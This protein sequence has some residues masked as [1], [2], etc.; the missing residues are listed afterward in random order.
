MFKTYKASAGSGKTTRLVAEYISVCLKNPERFRNILAITFTNNATAEMKER[1]VQTLQGFAFEKDYRQLSSSRKAVLEMIR[2]NIQLEEEK[3]E[4]FIREKSLALLQQILYDYAN[5]SISTIDS[6][7]QRLIRS[8]AIELNLN[9]NFDVELSKENLFTQTIDALLSKISKD[10]NSNEFSVTRKVMQLM[11]HNLRIYGRPNIERELIK[12]LRFMDNEE[13]YLPMKKLENTD[14]ENLTSAIKKLMRERDRLRNEIVEIAKRGDALVKNCGVEVDLFY[15]KSKG[16]YNFFKTIVQNPDKPGVCYMPKV[17]ENGYITA[18]PGI[19]SEEF[20]QLF[21]QYDQ[22]VSEL[23]TEYKLISIFSKNLNAFLLLFDLKKI[24]KQLN[25]HLNLVYISDS[26]KLIYDHIKDEDSPYIYEKLGNRYSTYLIDEFQDTSKMQWNNLLPLIKNAISGADQFGLSGKSI[27]FGDVKQ[28]IYRFRNGDSSLF[29]QLTTQE[30]YREAMKRNTVSSEEFENISLNTNYRSSEAVISFNN[31]FFEFL[32]NYQSRGKQVFALADDY[33]HDVKQQLPSYPIPKGLVTIRFKSEKDS[34]SQNEY[35]ERQL[36][37]EI[38]TALQ[39]G[40]SY[41]DIMILVKSNATR[42][43]YA[44]FL[45]SQ[46]IPVVS[47]DSLTLNSSPEVRV[48]LATMK[49][50]INQNDS[51]SKLTISHHLL[52]QAPDKISLQEA[53]DIQS[54]NKK[55][56]ELLELFKITIDVKHLGNLPLFTLFKELMLLYGFQRNANAFL[57]ELADVILDYT[58]RYKSDTAAFLVWWEESA[59]NPKLSSAADIDAVGL[60]SIH[61]SKGLQFPVVIFPLSQYRNAGGKDKF[62][63]EDEQ[64]STEIPA[65]P[66]NINKELEGTFL[67]EK[68]IEEAEMTA[69]DN[70]NVI[71]VAH[72][73]PQE[74]LHIISNSSSLNYGKFLKNFITENENFTHNEEL[75]LFYWG[76]IDYKPKQRAKKTAPDFPLSAFHTSDFS[77]ETSD[78][79]FSF[80]NE[81]TKAQELGITLHNYLSSLN[82]FPK[83]PDEIEMLPFGETEKERLKSLFEKVLQDEELYP[84]FSDGATVLNETDIVDI[85]GTL[86]RP[87]RISIVQDEVL[88]IDY[89]TGKENPEYERQLSRYVTLLQ[90]MGYT[91]V[92]GKLIFV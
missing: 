10:E 72:T 73:R 8:F 86:Y 68:Q 24:M 83:T 52:R 66:I 88:A 22:S 42:E 27:L 34:D 64:E 12:L 77:P 91:N 85:D 46:N 39:R 32:K 38:E 7:F 6:F 43:Q 78:L 55:F 89:K 74:C 81:K 61:Q 57:T 30:G 17:R 48:I 92:K 54:D 80:F 36:L 26:N 23:L 63:F 56:Q 33:Y 19:L 35:M 79:L 51:I 37:Y 49:Y 84:H 60:M 44:R 20:H 25:S 76:D 41:R 31:G 87:D 29:H 18:K 59:N 75:D 9:L 82:A 67:E 11:D 1:I 70:L 45:M 5:F 47:T 15:Y 2:A 69:L 3:A 50:I 62:W 13:S 65:F 53:L 71:Y 16:P 14:S 28:A 4:L 21:F 90:A 40:F 58:Q